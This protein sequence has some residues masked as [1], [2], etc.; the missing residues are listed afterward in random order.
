[1]YKAKRIRYQQYD[2]GKNCSLAQPF[3]E[4]CN[5]QKYGSLKPKE[6]DLA[7]IKAP[8]VSLWVFVCQG[9]ALARV[10]GVWWGIKT[11]LSM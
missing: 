3:Q 7:N 2:Y 5:Q 8:V 1:M 4:T 6:Y 9:S 11:L 10:E